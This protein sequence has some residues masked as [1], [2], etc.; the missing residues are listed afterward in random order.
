MGIRYYNRLKTAHLYSFSSNGD[1]VTST[2]IP[3]VRFGRKKRLKTA[4]ENKSWAEFQHI[5]SMVSARGLTTPTKA[6]NNN[7]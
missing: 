6:K 2:D 5:L 1:F 7:Y 3:G 4:A